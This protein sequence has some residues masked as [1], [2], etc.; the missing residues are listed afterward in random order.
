MELTLVLNGSLTP[1]GVSIAYNKEEGTLVAL[2][3]C[4]VE[5]IRF[6]WNEEYDFACGKCDKNAEPNGKPSPNGEDAPLDYGHGPLVD[7]VA[8]WTLLKKENIHLEVGEK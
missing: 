6:E 4:C 3:A 2:S 8:S 5:P 1:S 7:W